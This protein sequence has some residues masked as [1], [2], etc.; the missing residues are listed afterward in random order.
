M[1]RTRGKKVH[2]HVAQMIWA[3]HITT[4]TALLM[5]IVIHGATTALRTVHSQHQNCTPSVSSPKRLLFLIHPT[6]VHHYD[7][8]FSSSLSCLFPCLPLDST[9]YS[10]RMQFCRHLAKQWLSQQYMPVHSSPPCRSWAGDMLPFH[11]DWCSGPVLAW[12]DWW[13]TVAQEQ[14]KLCLFKLQV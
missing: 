10:T 4:I 8:W 9:S 7:I 1:Q 12:E 14:L 5:A 6:W 2:P 11:P 13:N 3:S